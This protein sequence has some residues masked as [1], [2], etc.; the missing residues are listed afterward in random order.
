MITIMSVYLPCFPSCS[1]VLTYG[2]LRRSGLHP[3]FDQI[4]WPG[5][6]PCSEVLTAECGISARECMIRLREAARDEY[7]SFL[8]V[9]CSMGICSETRLL[10]RLVR[11]WTLM[12]FSTGERVDMLIFPALIFCSEW[13]PVSQPSKLL[14][15]QSSLALDL[16]P[17]RGHSSVPGLYLVGRGLL[18][19]LLRILVV[20]PALALR[21]C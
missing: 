5:R 13:V 9:E 2:D 1:C 4:H 8:L 18:L 15:G 19:A 3:C 10:M 6:G 16:V 7:L 17:W 20:P 21:H 14:L 12:S 11:G